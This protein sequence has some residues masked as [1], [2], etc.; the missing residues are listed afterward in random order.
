MEMGVVLSKLSEMFFL[1]PLSVS[2]VS[3]GVVCRVWCGVVSR[4]SCLV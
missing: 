4:V 3:C 2:C 1:P